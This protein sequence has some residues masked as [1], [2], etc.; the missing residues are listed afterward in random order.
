MLS[1]SHICSFIL[2]GLK[3]TQYYVVFI[4]HNVCSYSTINDMVNSINK[5]LRLKI[6]GKQNKFPYFKYKL[7][8]PTQI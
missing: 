7:N 5:H 2:K 4:N 8:L 6:S 1:T 3:Y